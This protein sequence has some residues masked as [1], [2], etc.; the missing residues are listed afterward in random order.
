MC[1]R[2]STTLGTRICHQLCHLGWVNVLSLAFSFLCWMNMETTA[3]C[4]SQVGIQWEIPKSAAAEGRKVQHLVRAR[5]WARA[6]EPPFP[7]KPMSPTS[8]GKFISNIFKKI[9]FNFRLCHAAGG[10]LAPQAGLEP[11][12]PALGVQS[13]NHWTVREV[14][15][16]NIYMGKPKFRELR[17]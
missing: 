12:S 3:P 13:L 10:I 8:P 11:M 2:R 15:I 17:L 5:N 1:S 6:V 14:P 16:S 7:S 9:F 4:G